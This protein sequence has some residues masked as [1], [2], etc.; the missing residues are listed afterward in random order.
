MYDSATASSASSTPSFSTTSRC[1]TSRAVG[2]AVVRDP[3]VE[4]VDGDGDVVD[5]REHGHA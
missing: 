1:A 5:L 4:I 3:G 2:V